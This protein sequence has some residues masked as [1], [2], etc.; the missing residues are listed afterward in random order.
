[1]LIPIRQHF[2][3]RALPDVPAAVRAELESSGIAATL[4]PGARVAIGAGSRGISNLAAIVRAVVEY[5]TAHGMKPFLFPAMG[6]H[7][8]GTAEGQASVLAHY[9]IDEAAMGCP[10]ASTFD[11]VSLGRTESGS[12]APGIE[13]F[14]G[15]EAWE[16]DGIFVVSRV[17]WHTSFAGDLESGVSKMLAIGLGKLEGAKSVHGH[18]RTHG[19]DPSIRS[20]AQHLLATGRVLGGLAILEDAFHD[21]AKLAVLPAATLIRQE[22]ELLRTVK[23]WMVRIPVPAV[24]VL[25]VDEIGKNISGTG[26]DLKIVNRATTGQ[27]NPWP[28]EPKIERIFVRDLSPHSYGNAVGIGA[29]DVIHDRM[30]PKIDVNAGRVNAVTSG[31]LALVRTPLHFPSDRECLNL[32][33]ATVGKF[34]RSEVTF[35]W[36]RN[37]LELGDLFLSENLLQSNPELEVTG[38]P[39]DL[40]FDADGNLPCL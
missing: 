17:K 29:A 38:A 4:R 7:G 19:M 8:A 24:D 21:T 39:F 28:G 13:A 32:V 5:F 23:S 9:G 36:I 37:T 6:S 30:L 35:A 15:R 20:V 40:Q 31:S 12:P 3:H 14:A 33:A 22:E 27:Y 25:I 11:V 10:V 16:S 1:V 2:P 34:N 26:M 18:A